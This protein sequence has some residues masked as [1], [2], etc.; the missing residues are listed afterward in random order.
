MPNNSHIPKVK[1][2]EMQR[3][4]EGVKVL[5]K[6]YLRNREKQEEQRLMQMQREIRA[7]KKGPLE[8]EK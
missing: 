7:S 6:N 8:V 5:A 1:K 4:L 3:H 2:K